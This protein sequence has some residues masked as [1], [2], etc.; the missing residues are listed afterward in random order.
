MIKIFSCKKYVVFNN[1]IM[2]FNTHSR[3]K[4]KYLNYNFILHLL[5]L[6]T[7]WS[8]TATFI[9]PGSNTISIKSSN[10]AAAR[11]IM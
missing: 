1:S 2:T 8:Y 7:N 6:I 9:H 10:F 4:I 11:K 3:K 5:L